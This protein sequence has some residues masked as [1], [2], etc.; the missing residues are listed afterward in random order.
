MIGGEA[1]LGVIYSGEAIYTVKENPDL[2]YAIPKEGSN[3]WIDGWCI[4]KDAKHVENAEKFLNYL[5]RPDVAL[6]NF[7]YIGYSTPNTAARDLI[8]DEDLR[9]SEVA[10]PDEETL[11]RCETMSYLGPEAE[12]IYNSLWNQVKSS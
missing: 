7:D 9:N 10:F 1:A 6:K 2:A 11:S 3:V 12:E 4:P 8:E 5:C